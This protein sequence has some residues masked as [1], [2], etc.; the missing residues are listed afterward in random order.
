MPSLV[1]RTLLAAVVAA[2][3]LPAVASAQ[4]A[5][6]PP[7]Y[8]S[9]VQ[10]AINDLR[11]ARAS[12]HRTD[13]DSLAPAEQDAVARIDQGIHDLARAI[14]LEGSPAGVSEH[15]LFVDPEPH[16]RLRHA[17]D[18]LRS[19]RKDCEEAAQFAPGPYARNLV[20]SA[21]QEAESAEARTKA[22]LAALR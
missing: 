11:G 9:R 2:F 10:R 1:R 4:P 3:A 22:A 18:L 14:H 12:I 6:G 13:A 20:M 5:P 8:V 19:A 15:D 17:V 16:R 7:E 21:H